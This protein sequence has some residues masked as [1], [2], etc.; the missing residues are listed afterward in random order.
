MLLDEAASASVLTWN[1]ERAR[2]GTDAIESDIEVPVRFRL[3]R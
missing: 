3:T 1:F 2:V